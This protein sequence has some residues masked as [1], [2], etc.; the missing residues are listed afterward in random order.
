MGA[1]EDV[2]KRDTSGWMSKARE[3]WPDLVVLVSLE[4]ATT[5]LPGDRRFDQELFKHESRFW[6][7]H[8]GLIH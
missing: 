1:T 6:Y 3:A 8:R 5:L 2:Y 4:A 7:C